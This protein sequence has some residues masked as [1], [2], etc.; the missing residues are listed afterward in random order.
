M[1]TLLKGMAAG[2]IIAVPLGPVSLL[3]FRR[4]L[5]E[6]LLAGLLT[7]VG[8]ASADMIYGLAAAMGLT[9]VTRTLLSYPKVL[10]MGGGLFL[11]YFGMRM[12]RAHPEAGAGAEPRFRPSLH[13]SFLSAFVLTLANPTIA[14]SYL[15]VFAAIDPAAGRGG[16][17][18]AVLLG[19][20]IFL[21]SAAWWLVYKTAAIL[22][23][24]RLDNDGLRYIDVGAGTLICGF[25]IWQLIQLFVR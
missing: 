23:G 19:A 9:A 4:V 8:A 3:C 18:A 10:R 22:L 25:G 14:I 5:R 17:P 11:L 13:S 6:G 7:I 12:V 20:G 21:G 24:D 1:V 2:L 15:A 16:L